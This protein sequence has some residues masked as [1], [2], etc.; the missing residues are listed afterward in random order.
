[1][2]S[3]TFLQ[4]MN[5]VLGVV[6]LAHAIGGLIVNPDFATGGSA[7]AENFLWM[8]WNGW[9][10]LSGIFLWTT[11]LAVAPRAD[12]SRLFAWL[13][14]ATNLPVVIWML[15]DTVPFGLFALPTTGDLIFH[16]SLV[17]A[18]ALAL[19]ATRQK[20]LVQTS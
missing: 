8:D 11:A 15:F 18:Y 12:L 7:T 6:F 1:M 3:W 17:V 2:K 10:A 19:L 14:V 9:H 16:A 5:L 4:K 20:A 13:I